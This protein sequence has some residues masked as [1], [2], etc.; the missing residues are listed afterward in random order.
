[1]HVMPGDDLFFITSSKV[2]DQ[3]VY[4]CTATNSAGIIRANATITI[5]EFEFVVNLPNESE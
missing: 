3:G 1:M 5:R 4:T 2:S